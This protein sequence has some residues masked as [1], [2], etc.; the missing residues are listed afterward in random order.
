MSAG[1]VLDPFLCKHISRK[2]LV[3]HVNTS[4]SIAR[5]TI[6]TNLHI[7]KRPTCFFFHTQLYKP[8][9]MVNMLEI[10]SK[11]RLCKL[12]DDKMSSLGVPSPQ[13][14]LKQAC[15]K[16]DLHVPPVVKLDDVHV[17]NM[18]AQPDQYEKA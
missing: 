2:M 8:G 3:D 13:R 4:S 5:L 11:G 6:N 16:A 10:N 15:D 9:H 12:G 7:M 14:R 18:E 1:F 17:S